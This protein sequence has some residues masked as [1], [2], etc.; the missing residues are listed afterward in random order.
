MA[1]FETPNDFRNM[2]ATVYLENGRSYKG[3][4]QVHTNRYSRSAIKLYTE[5]DRK[6]MR[7]SLEDVK[8]FD[9]R[10]DYFELKE[11]KGGLRFVKEFSFMKRL[12]AENS[13]IHLFENTRKVT[14]PGGKHTG[15]NITYE[16]EYFLQLP[17]EPG[18]V[19]SLSSSRFVPN[20]DEKMSKLVEDC[21]SLSN[22]IASKEDG[23]FYAQVSLL[24]ERR[25]N[26]LMNIIEE[27]NKC[28]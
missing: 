25:A 23:Y 2:P 13:R 17:S 27:Y 12:T 7:F 22:K 15:S 20:F 11:I 6:P 16:I 1:Y 9:L 24:K 4:L 28:K 10:N 18:G 3:K 5:G 14:R 19:W 8:G 21:P 26:V